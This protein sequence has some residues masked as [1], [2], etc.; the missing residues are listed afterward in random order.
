MLGA[1]KTGKPTNCRNCDN[2]PEEMR[3]RCFKKEN[4]IE[5]ETKKGKFTA[6]ADTWEIIVEKMHELDPGIAVYD[7]FRQ[8]RICP[9][10]IITQ[11]SIG[12]WN[13]FNACGGLSV[14]T[15]DE[16][17]NLPAVYVDAVQ[18]ITEEIDKLRKSEDG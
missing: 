7:C 12:L 6:T 1:G 5:C 10:P 2:L 18:I 16:Y 3:P 11:T 8:F 13:V 4:E 15:P 9:L 14:R 17:Y